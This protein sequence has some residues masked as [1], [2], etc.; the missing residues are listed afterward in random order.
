M[1]IFFKP[2]KLMFNLKCHKMK[3]INY[4]EKKKNILNC[5]GLSKVYGIATPFLGKKLRNRWNLN[6]A[7]ENVQKIRDT[8][9]CFEAK[10]TPFFYLQVLKGCPTPV[11]LKSLSPTHTFRVTPEVYDFCVSY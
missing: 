6:M 7:L 9:A 8:N 1:L 10:K 11:H 4:H 2:L 3:K 5:G